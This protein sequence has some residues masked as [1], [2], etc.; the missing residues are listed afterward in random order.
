MK[1]SK[2]CD[3]GEASLLMIEVILLA[4]GPCMYGFDAVC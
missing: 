2:K 3:R 1:M 4:L